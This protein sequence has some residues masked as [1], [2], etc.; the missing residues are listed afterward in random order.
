MD[1]FE[2]LREF[3]MENSFFLLGKEYVCVMCVFRV[4]RIYILV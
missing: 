3:E 1:I 2:F 4:C